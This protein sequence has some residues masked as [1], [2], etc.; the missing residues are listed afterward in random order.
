MKKLIFI[1]LMLP[2]VSTTY[3]QK[4]IAN[5]PKLTNENLES[6]FLDWKKWS[7]KQMTNTKKSAL[8][9]LCWR[10]FLYFRNKAKV[11]TKYI[12]LPQSVQV[13]YYNDNFKLKP[14]RLDPDYKVVR[15]STISFGDTHAALIYPTVG[16]SNRLSQYLGGIPTREKP[17]VSIDK[18][19]EKKVSKYIEVHLGH[20]GGF[21]HIYSMPK[22][23]VVKVFRNGYVIDIR[24]DW[25]S[26]CS[27]FYQK[28]K[29]G[30]A[31]NG[32]IFEHWME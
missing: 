13:L 26:G 23:N 10:T 8:S 21:W 4:F 16:I 3:S 31:K 1:F 15:E 32:I 19:N 30:D 5:Y 22:I 14:S 11:K 7:D 12:S 2:S 6:F 17:F 9:D 28:D 27:I 20:W 29:I 18:G 25:Y 24:K